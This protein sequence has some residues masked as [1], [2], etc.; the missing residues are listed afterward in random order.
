MR[1]TGIRL[2]AVVALAVAAGV[3]TWLL[4]GRDKSSGTASTPT[5][6]TTPGAGIGPVGVSPAGLGTMVNT[7]HQ[8]VYWAGARP[9][10][11][12]EFT[13]TSAGKVYVRYLPAGV[14]VGD[15]RAD[16]LIVAT[17]PFANAYA[18]LKKVA[19]GREIALQGGGIA[20][21]DPGYPKSVHIAY[22][23]VP[24]QVE[25]FD[26]SPAQSLQVA[27]SGTVAPVS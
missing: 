13:Q 17:Y 11:T 25:V 18:A 19:A 12:Y 1:G 5:T 24:Y 10:N 3:V 16:F 27:L 23:K 7:I 2:G 21:V 15:K 22:P 8:P 14:K 6:V 20:F 9:G 26:P 4:V